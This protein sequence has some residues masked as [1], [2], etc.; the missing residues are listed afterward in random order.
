MQPRHLGPDTRR[1]ERLGAA[2]LLVAGPGSIAVLRAILPYHTTDS[3]AT[4]L[5]KVAAHQGAESA[6]L[7]LTVVGLLALV[8]SVLIVGRL[9]RPG[10]PL[11]SLLGLIFAVP[12]MVALFYANSDDLYLL[13][14]VGLDPKLVSQVIDGASSLPVNGAVTVIFLTGHVVG[15]ILLGFALWRSGVVPAW[16]A[17]LVVASQPF[18]ILFT[19]FLPVQVLDGAAW[20]LAT[21]GFAVC[22]VKVLRMPD[23]A[24]APRP[25]APVP[26]GSTTPARQAA[27]V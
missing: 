15:L 13:G 26:T 24:W 16:A 25:I 19:L 17:F 14:S 12:G 21:L 7:W 10:A 1:L 3:T 5:E 8:P 4:A 22:A 11:L 23:D 2:A 27:D 6:V 18:H 9:A 20:G